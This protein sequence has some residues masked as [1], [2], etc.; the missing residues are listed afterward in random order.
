MPAGKAGTSISSAGMARG[1]GAP[2]SVAG[3][4]NATA[5]SAAAAGGGCR[6]S[7]FSVVLVPSAN[8]GWLH[9]F[10]DP[11]ALASGSGSSQDQVI[12]HV[13]LFIFAARNLFCSIFTDVAELR[14]GL[15]QNSTDCRRTNMSKNPR[16]PTCRRLMKKCKCSTGSSNT[17]GRGGTKPKK[18]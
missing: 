4:G 11:A 7:P 3:C 13:V 2:R 9:L 5:R 12:C 14:C 18:G 17:D 1:L 15:R 6:R 16:C 10:P 8:T